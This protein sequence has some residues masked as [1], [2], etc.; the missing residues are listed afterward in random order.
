MTR[1]S[2]N[3]STWTDVILHHIQITPGVTIQQQACR[4][5]EAGNGGMKR[6]RC[7][8]LDHK[9]VHKLLNQPHPHCTQTKWGP[10]VLQWIHEV[11]EFDIY[12]AP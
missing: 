10:L 5:P 7:D 11:S 1:F 3:A 2:A 12:S 8:R 9:I 4:V 6:E